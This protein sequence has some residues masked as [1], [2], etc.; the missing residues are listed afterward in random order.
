MIIETIDQRIDACVEDSSEVQDILD[1]AWNITSRFFIKSVPTSNKLEVRW[2][3]Y[4]PNFQ[5]AHSK[6]LPSGHHGVRSPG[7]YEYGTMDNRHLEGFHQVFLSFLVKNFLCGAPEF[8]N[9]TQWWFCSPLQEKIDP[10]VTCHNSNGR[11]K[12]NLNVENSVI[13]VRPLDWS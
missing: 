10:C 2:F 1:K 12:E 3:W 9:S 5:N 11:S 6:F 8:P 13:E 7:N 4:F